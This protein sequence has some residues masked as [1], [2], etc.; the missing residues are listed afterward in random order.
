M[1]LVTFIIKNSSKMVKKIGVWDENRII[2]LA[3]GYTQKLIVENGCTI[4]VAERLASALIPEDMVDFIAG[5]MLSLNAAREVINFVSTIKKGEQVSGNYRF[6]YEE[7][8]ITLLA[9]LPKPV[10]IRDYCCFEEHILNCLRQMGM[11]QVIPPVFY[12]MPL[13]YKGNIFSVTGPE[14][15]V[16]WPHHSEILDYELEL[17]A[18]IGKKGK[19]ISKN[20]AGN[21]IFGYTIMNDFSARD[22]QKKE[23][24]GGLGPAKSK[25]F[26]TGTALGPCIVTTDEIADANNLQMV[27]RIN[28]EVWSEGNSSNM[29]WSFAEI[30]EQLSNSETLYPGEVL[31]SGTVGTGCGLELGKYLQPGDVVELEIEGIGVLRN[32]I[33]KH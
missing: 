29:Y 3:E 24:I 31:G 11:E 7:P 6:V 22:M 19:N 20:E 13:Y 12:Q 4:E 17:V 21:Y 28:G 1:K 16:V 23:M 27:A 33:V 5:G 10:S 15:D 2:D 9:P 14:S 32:R 25:D 18:I 26:D 30:I 8:H